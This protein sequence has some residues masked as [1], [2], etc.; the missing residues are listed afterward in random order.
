MDKE[1]ITAAVIAGDNDK[2]VIFKNFTPFND[3]I[4][5]KNNT[6]IDNAKDLDVVMPVFYLM[7]HSNNYSKTSWSLWQYCRD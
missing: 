1:Q 7:E 2:Q 6:Q 4:S 3:C 5:K